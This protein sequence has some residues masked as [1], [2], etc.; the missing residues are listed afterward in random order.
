MEGKFS[1]FSQHTYSSVNSAYPLKG[2]D[3]E[4]AEFVSSAV[5]ELI[6]TSL[7]HAKKSLDDND[8]IGDFNLISLSHSSFVDSTGSLVITMFTL[9][10]CE[11]K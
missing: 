7:E 8:K 3:L 9:H 6:T 2:V 11:E 5:K 4:K 10:E 1:I